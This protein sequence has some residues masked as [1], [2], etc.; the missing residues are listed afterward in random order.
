MQHVGIGRGSISFDS[1][2]GLND[3]ADATTGRAVFFRFTTV[4]HADTWRPGAWG[5]FNGVSW[6]FF[7]FP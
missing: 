2:A 6:T 3:F 5:L 4:D 1:T 7:D